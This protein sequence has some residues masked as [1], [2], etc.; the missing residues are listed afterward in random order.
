MLD[1][2]INAYQTTKEIVSAIFNFLI[3][4][5]T[6]LGLVLH[7]LMVGMALGL[8]SSFFYFLLLEVNIIS[9]TAMLFPIFGVVA[10]ITFSIELYSNL[11]AAPTRPINYLSFFN[12]QIDFDRFAGQVVS[13]GDYLQFRSDIPV[14]Y[15]IHYGNYRQ[16]REGDLLRNGSQSIFNEMD[17]NIPNPPI[18]HPTFEERLTAIGFNIDNLPADITAIR[19]SKDEELRTDHVYDSQTLAQLNGICPENRQ[20]FIEISENRELKARIGEFVS[21]QERIVANNV[22]RAVC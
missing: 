11:K 8:L 12:R 20:P 17:P 4:V 16:R 1:F 7:S 5:I 22:V 3:K 2:L 6:I 10:F 14:S 21:E 18:C 9:S 19:N 15:A 13:N